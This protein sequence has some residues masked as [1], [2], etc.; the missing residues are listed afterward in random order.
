MLASAPLYVSGTF[1]GGV[2]AAATIAVIIVTVYLW[3]LGDHRR[4]LTYSLLTAAPLVHSRVRGARTMNVKVLMDGT[5]VAK[6]HIVV[7]RI[8]N[9]SRRDIT[10][11]DFEGK[12]LQLDLGALIVDHLPSGGNT[13]EYEVSASAINLGPALI[14]GRET[15]EVT[16]I[17]DGFPHLTCRGR[18]VSTTIRELE[19]DYEDSSVAIT[20]FLALTLTVFWCFLGATNLT[21]QPA[22]KPDGVIALAYF[23]AGAAVVVMT[24]RT[25][26]RHRSAKKYGVRPPRVPPKSQPIPK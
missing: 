18:L 1:W 13:I 6:P 15:M 21:S 23:V 3:L 25:T 24:A 14:G 11:N 12:P 8:H 17:T 4:L 10:S 7:I 26:A 5:T 22:S 2:G 9:K 19:S 16:V 20:W